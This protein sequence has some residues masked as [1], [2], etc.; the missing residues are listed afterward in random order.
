MRYRGGYAEPTPNRSL[1]I[2]PDASRQLSRSP[3]CAFTALRELFREKRS[4]LSPL[5]MGYWA[6]VRREYPAPLTH[7]RTLH[8]ISH[9]SL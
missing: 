1:R 3:S 4:E 9:S 2:P 5:G 7:T 6:W 8:P